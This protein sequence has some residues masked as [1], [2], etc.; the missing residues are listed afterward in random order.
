M[1]EVAFSRLIEIPPRDAWG[2]EDRDFTP[3]L[4]DNID[5]LSEAIGL[6][7]E[8]TGTEVA[9]DSFS[10]DI[11]A[12]NQLDESI[13]LIE[14]QLET[15]DHKHLGQIMTYLAGLDAKTI[16][17]IAPSFRDAHLSSIN[18]LNE[19]T[20]EDFSFFAVKLRVVRI[21]GSPIA[22]VFEVA[23]KP[24][25]WS[26]SLADKRKSVSATHDPLS[27]TRLEFWTTYANSHT[28]AANAGVRPKRSWN[29]YFSFADGAIRLSLWIG[30]KR[31]GI[32]VGGRHGDKFSAK[33]LLDADGPAM[34]DKLGSTWY[35]ENAS[36]HV[37]GDRLEL[38]Y[39]DRANW[40][41]MYA[42]MEQKRAEYFAVLTSKFGAPDQ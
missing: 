24:D 25:G 8:L 23:A 30:E 32:Y 3:W 9:V 26:R 12:R 28:A 41:Q 19:H 13:V 15:T 38:S 27:D 37:L 18:W 31:G 5:Y 17:W 16:V 6:S 33:E 21:G 39:H 20:S 7:L 29:T 42:W 22:P 34:A 40:P 2:R 35:G 4:A 10:A 14:N 1:T 11:L 36:G